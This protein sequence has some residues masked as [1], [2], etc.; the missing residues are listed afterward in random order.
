MLQRLKSVVRKIIRPVLHQPEIDVAYDLL[1]TDYGGWP[2]VKELTHQT[3][4]IY[5]FGVGEDISFDLG[6]IDLYGM[7]VHAFDPTPRCLNWIEKQSLPAQFHFHP[8]G[9]SDVDGV[10]EFF[11]PAVEGY[12]SFSATPAKK[13]DPS[14]AVRAPVRRLETLIGELGTCAPDIVKFDIEGFEYGVLTDILA[15]PLRPAQLLI[16]FHHYMY[17]IPADRTRQAVVELQAA[18]YAIFYVSEI[19]HEYGFVDRERLAR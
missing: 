14:L 4:L 6:A 9:I 8:V 1:G 2:L 12:V 19:G 11:A 5:S 3:S 18:G 10:V 15:G 17:G 7:T 13:S 16:E